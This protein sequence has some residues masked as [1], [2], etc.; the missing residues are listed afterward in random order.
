MSISRDA[1]WTV[2]NSY[3]FPYNHTNNCGYEQKPSPPFSERN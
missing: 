3:T 2:A 1:K